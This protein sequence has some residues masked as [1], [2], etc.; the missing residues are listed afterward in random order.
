VNDP[1][2]AVV[3]DN[4]DPSG[5]GRV[6]VDSPA[7]GTGWRSGWA[8]VMQPCGSSRAVI[9]SKGEQVLLTFEAGDPVHPIVLGRIG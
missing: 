3:V 6:K 7:M 8:P 2:R 9:P 5:K 1:V 4:R